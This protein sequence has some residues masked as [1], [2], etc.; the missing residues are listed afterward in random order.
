[1]LE[2][3]A[4]QKDSK[5]IREER[6][7][8]EKDFHIEIGEMCI[9]L[10]QQYESV[11]KMPLWLYDRNKSDLAIFTGKEKYM[12]GRHKKTIDSAGLKKALKK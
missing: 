1:M 5:K 6:S 12:P 3:T 11:L 7:E 9:I 8:Y 4:Q 10:K 2:K